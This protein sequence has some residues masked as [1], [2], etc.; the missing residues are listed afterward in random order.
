MSDVTVEEYKA[1]ELQMSARGAWRGIRTHAAVTVAVVLALAVANAF[2][3]SEF[4]W[5][6]FP[7]A[8]M[9]LGVWF[10]WYFGVHS[11]EDSLVRHQG[12]VEQEALRKAA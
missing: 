11:G 5:S 1:E 4:P 6:V 10:H 3:A 9:S 12:E 2:V 8:G 7:A